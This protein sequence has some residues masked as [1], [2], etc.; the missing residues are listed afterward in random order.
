MIDEKDGKGGASVSGARER[1]GMSRKGSTA[2]NKPS[3][4]MDD[5]VS[6][7][8]EDLQNGSYSVWYSL[9]SVGQYTISV[10]T[11]GEHIKG[12]PYAIVGT[13]SQDI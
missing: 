10:M 5:D 3:S 6:V 2:S 8:Q 1:P 11:G 7:L 9:P 4:T 12:S 13:E